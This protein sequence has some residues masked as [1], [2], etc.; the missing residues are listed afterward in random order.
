MARTALAL[1]E[2]ALGIRPRLALLVEQ[3]AHPLEGGEPLLKLLLH[4]GARGALLPKL[5]LR[6][7]EANALL[8]E[9][10]L[11]YSQLLPPL[12]RCLSNGVR[13][14]PKALHLALRPGRSF[15]HL[16][17]RHAQ[18]CKLVRLDVSVAT[19]LLQKGK[20]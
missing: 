2:L 15:L 17:K 18:V 5:G 8:L 19:Q 13:A 10:A 6:P 16:P 20:T 1:L 12:V 4:L 7:L 9:A 3:S 14:A 11:D